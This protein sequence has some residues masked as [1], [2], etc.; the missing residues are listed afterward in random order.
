[1]NLRLPDENETSFLGPQGHARMDREVHRRRPVVVKTEDQLVS[2]V[3]DRM[4]LE[5]EALKQLCLYEE[6][7]QAI[8]RYRAGWISRITPTRTQI[9]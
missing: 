2:E 7:K 5:M 9:P 3:F 6:Y 1:M 8:V 4:L